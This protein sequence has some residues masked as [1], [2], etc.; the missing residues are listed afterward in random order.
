V[1]SENDKRAAWM[2]FTEKY[3]IDRDF[4][5]DW[6]DPL[7]TLDTALYIDPFLIWEEKKGFW[8]DAHAHLL[9]F[10]NMVFSLI[11][12]SKGNESS[13]YWKKAAQLLL[14]PEPPEFC[15]GVSEG[16]PLGQGS[17][18]GLQKDMLG[19]TKSAINVGMSRITHMETISLFQG[20]M[21]PDRISDAVC[22]VLKS[23]FIQYTKEVCEKYQQI[24]TEQ[25]LVKNASWS[26]EYCKWNDEWHDLP[27]NTV[28]YTRRGKWRSRKIPVL[29]TPQRF[30]RDLPM[31]NADDFWTHSWAT[32]GA[33]LRGNFNFDITRHV[34]RQ[35]KARLAR[36]NPEAVVIYLKHVEE[37]E[38]KPYPIE[39]DPRML[40]N[41]YGEGGVIEHIS[42]NK[43]TPEETADFPKL[44]DSIV[45]SYAHGIEHSD[46]WELLWQ[47]GRGAPE[48]AVQA[49]FRSVVIHY[50]R[51]QEIGLSGEANA[52]RGPV[53]FKFSRGWS[54]QAL[55]EVK[56]VR[57]SKLWDGILAQLPEYQVS[58]E[59]KTGRLLA[60]AYN[61]GE[62]SQNIRAK[63]AEAAELAAKKHGIS[64]Q[65]RLIDARRKQS[66]SKLKDRELSNALHDREE[67]DG[68]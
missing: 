26:T 57:S 36:E 66:A 61:D 52:G 35:E 7:L 21:G 50:C 23:Y 31:A 3:R 39:Q 62:Y 10:F 25:I 59:V 22:N 14:F 20:G 45:D 33:E 17:A 63:L 8:R 53:D 29:L 37:L 1:Q 40:V 67:K 28:N 24:E 48:R 32:L 15:L 43:F 47:T 9:D 11:R 12:D 13:I 38:K 4:H 49:L 30:L 34:G 46:A 55:V 44:I 60:I 41:W 58:E 42:S 54:A 6:Y 51:S 5:D 64:I 27:V 68:D 19:G 18:K 16:S 56:L 65:A 2:K